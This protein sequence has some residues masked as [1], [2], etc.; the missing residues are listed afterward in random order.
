TQTGD[1]H[2]NVVMDDIGAVHLY[3]LSDPRNKL[4]NSP[5]VFIG[6]NYIPSSDWENVPS[7]LGAGGVKHIK[8]IA[9][10]EAGKRYALMIKTGDAN[11]KASGVLASVKLGDQVIER[12]G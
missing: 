11:G 7:V 8:G 4:G 1:Y 5:K 9:R 3:D 6:P 2:V 12:T 10:L